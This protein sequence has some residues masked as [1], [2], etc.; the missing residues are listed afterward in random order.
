VG[1]VDDDRR[2][3]GQWIG[4]RPVL[5]PISKLPEI[6]R[7][8]EVEQLLFAIP[9]M[10]AERLREILAACA[11]L[12]LSYKILPVSFAYLNDRADLKALS[13]LSPDHLLPRHEVQFDDA[14]LDGLVRG[15][16]ILVTGAAGSI[17]SEPAGRSPHTRRR[18]WCSPTS[19]RTTSTSSTDTCATC[20]P[21]C[22]STR[23][24]ST[25][26]TRPASSSCCAIAGLRT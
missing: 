25:S 18:G 11:E 12:K 20:T 22:G 10:P 24:S 1:Y 21:S 3:W 19:T 7:S 14:E 13:D 9:R 16:R 17:G 23:R 2:K 6:A 26:A 5:G 15:R 4:G 8:R